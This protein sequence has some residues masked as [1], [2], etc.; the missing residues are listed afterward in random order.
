ASARDLSADLITLRRSL[1]PKHADS[2]VVAPSPMAPLAMSRTAARALLL[3]IQIGYLG[4][5]A[6]ALYKFHDVLR[7]SQELYGT[8]V[9]GQTLLLAGVVGVPVWLFL[10]TGVRPGYFAF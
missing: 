9:L 4:M 5:Y 2:A 7:V 3:L 1:E 10:F 8:A 6:I